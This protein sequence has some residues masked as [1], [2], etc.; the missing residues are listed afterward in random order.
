[1]LL[2]S[3]QVTFEVIKFSLLKEICS[4]YMLAVVSWLDRTKSCMP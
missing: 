1:L 2:A 3:R 4:Q